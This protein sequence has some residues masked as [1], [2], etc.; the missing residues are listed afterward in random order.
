MIETSQAGIALEYY[1]SGDEIPVDAVDGLLG[2]EFRYEAMTTAHPRLRRTIAT[3]PFLSG[4][5]RYF[6]VLHWD[7]GTDLDLLDTLAA[8]GADVSS[9]I[10]R[11]LYC[12]V[13]GATCQVCHTPQLL[14]SPEAGLP[15]SSLPRLRAHRLSYTCP[16]CGDTR[17]AQHAEVLDG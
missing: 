3:F 6:G 11:A 10:D 7:D 15:T 17:F 12:A 8:G 13:G 2:Y 9:A 1:P 4:S 5:A 14:V 16:N